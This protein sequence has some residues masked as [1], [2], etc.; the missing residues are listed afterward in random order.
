MANKT[1]YPME[2]LPP[3]MLNKKKKEEEEEEQTNE[4][5]EEQVWRI[6]KGK[7]GWECASVE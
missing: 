1:E 7:T 2:I 6:T 3:K 5:N 4:Q